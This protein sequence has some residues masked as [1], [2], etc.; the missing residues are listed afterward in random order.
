MAAAAVAEHSREVAAAQAKQADRPQSLHPRQQ[1]DGDSSDDSSCSGGRKS[2]G[3]DSSEGVLRPPARK[4]RRRAA[5]V[6]AAAT[7]SAGGSP[8]SSAVKRSSAPVRLRIGLSAWLALCVD[9][10]LLPEHRAVRDLCRVFRAGWVAEQ[11]ARAQ[12][13]AKR[14]AAALLEAGPPG[15]GGERARAASFAA[16]ADALGGPSSADGPSVREKTRA[17]SFKSASAAPVWHLCLGPT[18]FRH[19]LLVLASEY[20]W[21]SYGIPG[22]PDL[23]VG[24][25]SFVGSSSSA[26]MQA[27][28]PLRPSAS[29]P[30]STSF[31]MT[32][33]D[34]GMS[35]AAAA[36][37]LKTI[38]LAQTDS[39]V[40][41][42][43]D[44]QK[45]A[46]LG[47][48]AAVGGAAGRASAAQLTPTLRLAVF[49]SECVWPAAQR[50]F[51][52]MG[53]VSP[54]WD[55]YS[56]A[57]AVA[58]ASAA[59]SA[60]AA[61]PLPPHRPAGAPL[62]G[63]AIAPAPARVLRR[64]DTYN[65]LYG[66]DADPQQA[67]RPAA[68]AASSTATPTEPSSGELPH[69]PPSD[70]AAHVLVVAAE[71]VADRHARATAAQ[72][73]AS[74]GVA[75][76]AELVRTAASS[77]SDISGS[78]AAI[79]PPSDGKLGSPPPAS[80][81]AVDVSLVQGP[82]QAFSQLPSP[83]L[84]VT[85]LA[86]IV[87]AD[88]STTE[89][90]RALA[91]GVDPE[92]EAS[93][94]DGAATTAASKAQNWRASF[95]VAPV[96]V[97]PTLLPKQTKQATPAESAG[98]DV[99]SEPRDDDN[100]SGAV[101]SSAAPAP[102]PAPDP[103]GASALLRVMSRWNPFWSPRSVCD[104]PV[105]GATPLALLSDA[106]VIG[107]L[108]RY[109]SHISAV[110]AAYA[111]NAAPPDAAE[112]DDLR[113]PTSPVSG[114]GE[115]DFL[116]LGRSHAAENDDAA[117]SKANYRISNAV[118][119]RV[120]PWW[121]NDS[122]PFG[123]PFGELMAFA[124]ASFA[125]GA[126]AAR[127]DR[128]LTSAAGDGDKQV[129][130]AGKAKGK[131][132]SSAALAAASPSR[133]KAA[134]G[135][136]VSPSV[137]GA[138]TSPR[139]VASSSASARVML[140]WAMR[141]RR[142]RD[143]AAD[144]TER[145]GGALESGLVLLRM[146]HA[147]FVRAL[148]SSGLVPEHVLRVPACRVLLLR[149]FL[150]CAAPLP[151][152]DA[153]TV[154]NSVRMAQARLMLEYRDALDDAERAI[155]AAQKELSGQSSAADVRGRGPAAQGSSVAQATAAALRR[156][157]LSA[158]RR[159]SFSLEDVTG[160]ASESRSGQHGD[161]G[162]ES[163]STPAGAAPVTN[164]V[165][166]GGAHV[167]F[168]SAATATAA[169]SSY[170]AARARNA[171][172]GDDGNAGVRRR[173]VLSSHGRRVSFAGSD[174][175]A[176]LPDT[177][178][179]TDPE[180]EHLRKFDDLAASKE[181]RMRR[182][183]EA[184][185]TVVAASHMQVASSSEAQVYAKARRVIGDGA[186]RDADTD[187]SGDSDHDGQGLSKARRLETH[188]RSSAASAGRRASRDRADEQGVASLR[189]P[190]A[191]PSVASPRR[192]SN[193]GSVAAAGAEQHVDT[194]LRRRRLSV[195]QEASSMARAVAQNDD[196][197][198][199]TSLIQSQLVPTAM[200]SSEEVVEVLVVGHGAVDSPVPGTASQSRLVPNQVVLARA[201]AQSRDDASNFSSAALPRV[202]FA[203]MASDA[204]V[205]D[206]VSDRMNL[207]SRRLSHAEQV[208]D[209]AA[210]MSSADFASL[211]F[212]RLLHPS[213][214][215]LGGGAVGPPNKPSGLRDSEAARSRTRSEKDDTP[216]V[217]A[218]SD[219]GTVRPRNDSR[220]KTRGVSIAAPSEEN[221]IGDPTMLSGRA[222]L[223]ALE[224]EVRYVRS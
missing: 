139:S 224:P 151:D 191:S 78:S 221:D 76:P 153:A 112:N 17:A 20:L 89:E 115:V 167:M 59:K 116:G 133:T 141:M 103:I 134:A 108:L 86:R 50:R 122:L 188:R 67:R 15:G 47:R 35:R 43:P 157:A 60:A 143:Q 196:G 135:R 45:M 198:S 41:A 172:D 208:P 192:A 114:S 193:A 126:A 2:A 209:A 93:G 52:L 10:G 29:S 113:P 105:L 164:V 87:E 30:S 160:I 19:A 34:S 84:P 54:T 28:S 16:G 68:A 12:R 165:S 106:R 169:L 200:M 40:A 178:A 42:A 175:A 73:I 55:A 147:D 128:L 107:L 220:R 83:Q 217:A 91:D 117:A 215:P 203:S 53:G 11:A 144:L 13:R 124:A 1:R 110:F 223:L 177:D 25:T 4:A 88:L 31:S 32:A 39:A 136:S 6:A 195:S 207:A 150:S 120:A 119:C 183:S 212:R 27:P 132:A 104:A 180:T 218:T 82:P 46:A 187:S 63:V 148:T 69:G 121:V 146:Q 74:A 75:L 185:S 138:A 48:Q 44:R 186:A 211:K 70:A 176:H 149:V 26:A 199:S 170:T 206:L 130:G 123:A 156:A 173:S 182:M 145:S 155:A 162:G 66:P 77:P 109:E 184:A 159:S 62:G 163:A 158:A 38:V 140:P 127:V 58:R 56:L 23:A 181:L 36:L 94:A 168:A 79:L 197:T 97:A 81:S 37:L 171:L 21:R 137:D 49:L 92:S 210:T 205:V 125:E 201:L 14:A 99:P 154:S 57:S 24:G 101:S 194:Q 95:L 189:R 18:G 102:I 5:V 213:V 71:A 98:V 7:S 72:A 90:M 131:S 161:H 111:T 80:M 216:I 202:S 179:G 118:R 64:L 174:A 9:A 33:P 22:D 96:E 222:A 204:T 85:P 142:V 219:G 190:S 51:L 214:Q 61:P 100:P 3:S 65:V 8:P 129:S 152:A 166:E